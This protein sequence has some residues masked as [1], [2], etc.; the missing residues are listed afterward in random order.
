MLE[1]NAILREF[2]EWMT[3]MRH[4]AGAGTQEEA[5]ELIG[6]SRL[7]LVRWEKGVNLPSSKQ[8]QRIAD[9]YFVDAAEVAR[10]AGQQIESQMKLSDRTL[11]LACRIERRAADLPGPQW[12]A[13]ERLIEAAMSMNG[14]KA[15]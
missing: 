8:F 1:Q 2:G 14:Q 10:R 6:V 13:L 4:K 11:S 9:A 15:S 5:A 12:A 7:Q 3:M